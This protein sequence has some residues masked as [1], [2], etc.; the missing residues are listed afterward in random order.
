MCKN[1]SFRLSSS[2][3]KTT[4]S[5]LSACNESRKTSNWKKKKRKHDNMRNLLCK[6][7]LQSTSSLT[8]VQSAIS[9]Q[10]F[11]RQN[12]TIAQAING[13]T[14]ISL[15]T[16]LQYCSEHI[17]FGLDLLW[18]C[19]YSSAE[20]QTLMFTKSQGPGPPDKPSNTIYTHTRLTTKLKQN[21]SHSLTQTTHNPNNTF[22]H[23]SLR[24]QVKICIQTLCALE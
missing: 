13:H 12:K 6:K 1:A 10:T 17:L 18:E 24:L 3:K 2:R 7:V 14:L 16:T 5:A 11:N 20:D 9:T 21:K 15:L 22:S 23:K 19:Q 8:C 4:T